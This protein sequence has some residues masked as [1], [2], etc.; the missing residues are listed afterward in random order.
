MPPRFIRGDANGDGMVE[1][2]DALR[3]LFIEFVGM[4]SD[5]LDAADA[6]DNRIVEVAD[7]IH[8][9]SYLFRSG[10]PPDPPFP[11]AGDDPTADDLGCDRR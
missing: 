9:L 1:L 11:I 5:C 4:A 3:I 7:A 2:S 10:E 8:V 6:D